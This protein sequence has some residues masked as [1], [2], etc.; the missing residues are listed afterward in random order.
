MS[1]SHGSL[2]R[3]VIIGKSVDSIAQGYVDID[4]GLSP[5]LERY[6]WIMNYTYRD[7]VWDYT[8]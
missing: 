5:P 2:I 6:F 4:L 1:L 8:H 3:G 7:L